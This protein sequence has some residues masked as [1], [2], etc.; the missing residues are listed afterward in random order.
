[1]LSKDFEM[2]KR[3]NG[4]VYFDVVNMYDL[5]PNGFLLWAYNRQ[6]SQAVPDVAL[7]NLNRLVY[8]SERLLQKSFWALLSSAAIIFKWANPVICTRAS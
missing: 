2:D 6:F 4:L 3:K 1:M 7:E 5:N 8:W